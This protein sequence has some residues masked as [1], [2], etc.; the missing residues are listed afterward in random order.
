M[1]G[2]RNTV[3]LLGTATLSSFSPGA[4]SAGFG[5]TTMQ[6]RV[7]PLIE[8]VAAAILRMRWNNARATELC[9]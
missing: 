2:S 5:W 7:I 4:L 3:L 1:A 6:L 9:G 8:V